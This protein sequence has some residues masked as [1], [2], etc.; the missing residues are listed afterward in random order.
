M[1]LRQFIFRGIDTKDSSAKPIEDKLSTFI[2]KNEKDIV[3]VLDM[4]N[5]NP[6]AD[7]HSS[8][9]SK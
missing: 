2:E 8:D 7:T 3:G 1:G 9:S 4:F 6:N 5:T